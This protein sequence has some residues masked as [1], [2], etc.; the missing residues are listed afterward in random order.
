MNG[1][2]SALIQG[3]LGAKT[4]DLNHYARFNDPLNDVNSG[5]NVNLNRLILSFLLTFL[6]L[7]PLDRSSLFLKTYA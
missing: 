5:K 3:Y 4:H 6:C 7:L 2:A 1:K